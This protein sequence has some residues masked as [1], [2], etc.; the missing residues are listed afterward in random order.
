MTAALVCRSISAGME[1]VQRLLGSSADA[2]E[3]ERQ[4]L[5]DAN[6]TRVDKT[7][8]EKRNAPMPSALN[9]YTGFA[10]SN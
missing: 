7:L 8:S 1:N 3:H 6:V 10:N 5:N 9:G 4:Y 2:A